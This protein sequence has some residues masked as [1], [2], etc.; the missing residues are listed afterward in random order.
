MSYEEV[1][2]A[3]K[4]ISDFVVRTPIVTNATIN[5]LTGREIFFKCENL[6]KTG[7]FKVRGAL[8]SMISLKKNC[9]SLPGV[10]THSSGNHGIA[11]AYA[12]KLNNLPCCVVLP[13]ITSKVKVQEVRNS[14][15]EVILCEPTQ[16]SRREACE[17]VQK[18]RGMAFIPPYDHP[19]VIAG[20]GTIGKEIMEQVEDLDAIIAPVSGGGLSSGI[21]IGAKGINSNVKMYLAEPEGKETERSLRAGERLWPNPPQSLRSVAD[22]LTTQQ[23]GQLTWP[24]LKELAEKEVFTMN[25][26]QIISAMKLA[27]ENLKLVIEPAAAVGVAAILSNQ[28]QRI[29]PS[30]KRI[31]VVLCGGNVNLDNIP[32]ACS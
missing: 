30:V 2:V 1:L 5:K 13:N 4:R 15:A 28:M 21:A 32:W 6:Q 7:S 12:A 17:K 16:L 9:K 18:E 25:D 3:A 19:D 22:A 27:W 8:N 14:D 23:L 31:C 11:V 24:I 26:D 10:T 20:Q 29:P